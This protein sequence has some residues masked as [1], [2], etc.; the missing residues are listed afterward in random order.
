MIGPLMRHL[1]RADYTEM[2]WANGRGT[3][4]EIL[5]CDDAAGK[6]WRFSMA[7][8]AEN[9]PFS[10]FPG[11]D[12]NLTVIDGPGFD[13]Q[14]DASLRADPMRPLAFSGDIALCAQNVTG[15]SVDFNVM[16]RRSLPRPKVEVVQNQSVAAAPGA[17]LCLFAL[18]NARFG[19]TLIK[20]HDFLWSA[21]AATATGAPFLAIHLFTSAP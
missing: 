9:G 11:I 12:R 3:T 13:L 5:R 18:G 19:N 7:T 15:V 2:P 1:T 8:I 16:T 10:Q 20:R 14:G 6:V 21:T 17:T 4:I